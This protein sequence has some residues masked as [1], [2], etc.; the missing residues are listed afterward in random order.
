MLI[1]GT[2]FKER[3]P[4]DFQTKKAAFESDKKT[5]FPNQ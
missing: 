3:I 5:K 4:D 1:K 2:V